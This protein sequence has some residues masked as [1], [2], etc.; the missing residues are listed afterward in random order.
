MEKVVEYRQ[1]V[2]ILAMFM[3]VQFFG[4]LVAT[5]MFS[6]V[7]IQQIRA[8]TLSNSVLNVVFYIAYIAMFSLLLVLLFKFIKS[9]LLFKAMEALVILVSSFAIFYILLVT[10]FGNSIYATALALAFGAI[11]VYAKNKWPFLKNTAAIIASIGVGVILGSSFSFLFSYLFMA[12][13]GIY[14]FIAVFITKHMISLANAAQENNL[15]FMVEVDEIKGVPENEVSKSY[16]NE[17]KK[18]YKDSSAFKKVFSKKLMPVAARVGLGTGDLAM[19]LMLAVSA[20]S[21]TLNFTLSF[22][23][24]IGGIL[25]LIATMFILRK[26]KRALP[27]IPPLFFGISIMVLAYILIYGPK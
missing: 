20:Y 3:I 8:E 18:K 10:A 1:M 5:L 12:A 7:T 23:V 15:A 16:A 11:I 9:S 13:L 17:V 25:G 4:L 24:I 26:Y 14:D 2:H 21:A 22:F 19:P 27:A 6:G